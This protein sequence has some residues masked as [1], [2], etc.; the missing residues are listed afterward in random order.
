MS[1]YHSDQKRDARQWA[2]LLSDLSDDTDVPH[3]MESS[4][5]SLAATLP[6]GGDGVGFSEPGPRSQ[7]GRAQFNQQHLD[8]KSAAISNRD[9][10]AVGR[11][12]KSGSER[13]CGSG[14]T[15]AEIPHGRGDDAASVRVREKQA[16][17]PQPGT[18]Q[19]AHPWQTSSG[20]TS[21]S[22]VGVR[23]FALIESPGDIPQSVGDDVGLSEPGE[24][25][26]P[27]LWHPGA[28]IWVPVNFPHPQLFC[29]NPSVSSPWPQNPV[30]SQSDAETLPRASSWQHRETVSV[31]MKN[32]PEHCTRDDVA[33]ELKFEGFGA[34]FYFVYVRFDFNTKKHCG[35]AHVGVNDMETAEQ[36]RHCFNGHRFRGH[37]PEST[38]PRPQAQLKVEVSKSQDD[39]VEKYR[40]SNLMHRAV[41]NRWKP[42]MY[43]CGK[44]VSFPNPNRQ[45]DMPKELLRARRRDK[46]AP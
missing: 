14:E 31:V 40:N 12:D 16:G 32:I 11:E 2:D 44:R 38:D 25:V 20:G 29:L 33:E 23:F 43:Q 15:A 36:I 17:S 13:I 41:P 19:Q 30:P 26:H 39:L 9:V 34:K 3:S 24:T 4:D 22:P 27:P 37:Q 1:R 10:A 42:A 21:W 6:G 18:A 35:W 5:E 8:D 7:N 46:K 28:A 45:L